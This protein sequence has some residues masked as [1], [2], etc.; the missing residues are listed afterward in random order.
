MT[1][2]AKR[3]AAMFLLCF[4][5][6]L[7]IAALADNN[8]VDQKDL[9]GQYGTYRI[10]LRKWQIVNSINVGDC[11]KYDLSNFGEGTTGVSPCLWNNALLGDQDDWQH[12]GQGALGLGAIGVILIGFGA[13]FTLV[14][15]AK[16][17]F[18]KAPGAIVSFA[19]GICF[20]IGALIYDGMRPSMG[21][22]MGYRYPIGL[23]LAAGLMT[24]FVAILLWSADFAGK[25]AIDSRL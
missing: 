21:G 24:E 20:L 12:A 8:W 17:E 13:I 22:D 14:Q 9:D 23:Y 25:H 1:F 3:S 11:P 15:L 7:A 2:V 5:L 6:A 16:P 18:S 4:G 10:G 19:A